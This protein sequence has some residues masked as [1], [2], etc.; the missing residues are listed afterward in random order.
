MT[1]KEKSAVCNAV[2]RGIAALET[3]RDRDRAVTAIG[4]ELEQELGAG[5]GPDRLFISVDVVRTSRDPG[6]ERSTR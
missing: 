4:R 1:G 5:F 2:A 6:L 3:E